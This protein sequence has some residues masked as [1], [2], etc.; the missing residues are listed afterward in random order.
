VVCPSQSP[1]AELVGRANGRAIRDSRRY[2][3]EKR[4]CDETYCS[5]VSNIHCSASS[6]G[7]GPRRRP[8][9][10][11]MSK[12][13]LTS[14]FPPT[15]SPF[16]L[17]LH[18]SPGSLSNVDD[19]LTPNRDRKSIKAQIIVRAAL[20]ESHARS[21]FRVAKPR[22][23]LGFDITFGLAC[24]QLALGFPQDWGHREWSR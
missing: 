3:G 24:L 19:V 23:Q 15:A 13:E 18:V 17:P 5:L 20:V 21:D 6:G 4:A 10:R 12:D 8:T 2:P 16:L 22:P 1:K 11:Q 7:K 9:Y 14:L